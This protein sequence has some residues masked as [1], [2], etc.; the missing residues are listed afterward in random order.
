MHESEKFW[1]QSTRSAPSHAGEARGARAFTL[2][3]VLQRSTSNEELGSR[4]K[5]GERLVESRLV[6]LETMGLFHP[7]TTVS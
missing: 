7:I 6:V 1:A 4:R 5:P 2:D 3:V